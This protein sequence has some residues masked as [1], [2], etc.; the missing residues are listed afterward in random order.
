[1]KKR[2]GIAV[3]VAVI[4][5]ISLVLVFFIFKP[6]T[7]MG[8]KAITVNVI[9]SD[10]SVRTFKYKTDVEYLSDVVVSDGLVQGEQAEYG[11]WITTVD[12]EVADASKE[13]WWGILVNGDLGQYG[14]DAQPIADGDIYEFKFNV[15]YENYN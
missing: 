6:N 1:M 3:L 15:G 7:N 12:G 4:L 10:N 9:H 14:V 5:V 2:A 8:T 11:L 13:E